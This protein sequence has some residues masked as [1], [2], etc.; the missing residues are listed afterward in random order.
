MQRTTTK[1]GGLIILES[2]VAVVI[3]SLGILGI[4]GLL[5]LSVKNTESAKYRNVAGLLANSIT[6]Q[7][8]VDDKTNASLK[9]NFESPYGTQFVAW[10]S[11]VIDALPGIEANPPTITINTSNVATITVWWQAPGEPAAHNYIL[12]ALIIN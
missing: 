8:W 7:M 4:V 9:T 5:T 10:K 11:K 1:Q 3:F 2:L 12:N 6:G